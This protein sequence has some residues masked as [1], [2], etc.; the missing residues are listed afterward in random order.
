MTKRRLIGQKPDAGA[1]HRTRHVWRV[2]GLS[3]CPR[4]AKSDKSDKCPVCPV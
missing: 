1:G 3:G 2:S 4:Y